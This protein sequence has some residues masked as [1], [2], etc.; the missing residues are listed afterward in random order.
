MLLLLRVR[1][2]LVFTVNILGDPAINLLAIII[3]TLSLFLYLAAFGSMYWNP[4]LTKLEF[5]FHTNLLLTAAVTLYARFTGGNQEVVAHTFVSIPLVSLGGILCYHLL[6]VL[7]TY[8]VWTWIHKLRPALRENENIELE[9]E[10]RSHNNN[11]NEQTGQEQGRMQKE[12]THLE[13][14]FNTE[15]REPVLCDI[16]T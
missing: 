9:L 16:K 8:Q 4:Y 15:Y 11:D 6:L 5:L 3:A 2:I 7:K 10:V 12:V 13:P 14:R 1:L